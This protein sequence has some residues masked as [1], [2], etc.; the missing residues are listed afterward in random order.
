[1]STKQYRILRAW[2][3]A[4]SDCC[5]QKGAWVSAGEVAKKM[6][7]SRNTSKKYLSQLVN[8]RSAVAHKVIHVNGMEATLYAPIEGD[9]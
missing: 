4:L 3:D 5:N 1:M 8:G 7:E 2:Y 9:N 6:G